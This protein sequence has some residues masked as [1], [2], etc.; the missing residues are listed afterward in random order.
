MPRAAAPFEGFILRPLV[1]SDLDAYEVVQREGLPDPFTKQGLREELNNDLT[2]SIAAFDQ[3][4][5]CGAVL[6]WLVVDELQILQV[7]VAAP[8]RRRGL[9]RHLL[10]AMLRRARAAGAGFATLEVR[11]SNTPARAL[12]DDLGFLFDAIRPGYYCDGEDA[13]LMTLHLDRG[14]LAFDK[15]ATSP[16]LDDAQEA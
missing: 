4:Q 3:G 12:Y 11:V 5:L 8:W 7:V 6:C 1:P 10:V 2:R 14:P 9:G 16:S 13:A 15:P